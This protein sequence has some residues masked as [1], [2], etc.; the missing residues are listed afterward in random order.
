VFSQVLAAQAGDAEVS[1]VEEYFNIDIEDYPRLNNGLDGR[2]LTV[3]TRLYQLGMLYGHRFPLKGN[4]FEIDTELGLSAN[5]GSAN[6]IYS[7]NRDFS[8]LNVRFDDTLNQ[9]YKQYAFIPSVAVMLVYK[10]KKPE[11]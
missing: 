7:Q 1:L 10:F 6:K 4:R 2:Y 5:I 8:K 11:N 3:R 9:F